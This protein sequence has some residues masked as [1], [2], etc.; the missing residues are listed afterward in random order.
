MM[1]PSRSMD[2][3]SMTAYKLDPSLIKKT[4]DTLLRFCLHKVAVTADIERAFLMI[5]MTDKDH[6]VLQFL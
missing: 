4:L 5:A 3:L 1:L 2:L 6:D